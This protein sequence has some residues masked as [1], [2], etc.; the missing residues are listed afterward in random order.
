VCVCGSVEV[1]LYGNDKQNS[2]LNPKPQTPDPRLYGND[3]QKEAPFSESLFLHILL[4][5]FPYGARK[6][7][8]TLAETPDI[9]TYCFTHIASHILLHTYC[10][11]HTTTRKQKE[12]S[13][14]KV[15]SYHG[16]PTY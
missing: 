6:Q 15:P 10:F 8:M 16:T 11:T 13:F 3:K 14:S 2:V 7:K 9:H 5:K 1:P 4:H 12:A